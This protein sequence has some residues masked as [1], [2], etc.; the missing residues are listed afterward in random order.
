VKRGWLATGVLLVCIS[1]LLPRGLAPVQAQSARALELTLKQ[2]LTGHHGP[3]EAL[4]ISPDGLRVAL[5]VGSYVH[6]LRLESGKLERTLVGHREFVTSVAWSRDGRTLASASD[7]D[8]V[9]LWNASSGTSLHVLTGVKGDINAVAFSPDGKRLAAGGDDKLVRIWDV[10]SGTPGRVLRGTSTRLRAL[11]W[12][13]DARALAVAS[14]DAIVRVYDPTSGK[15][16]RELP[17]A[18]DGSRA[19]AFSAD[20]K[21]AAAGTDALIRLWGA[22]SNAPRVLRGHERTV[23]GLAFAKDGRQLASVGF[24][25]GVRLWN[26]RDGSSRQFVGHKDSV[27]ALAFVPVNR[28]AE[29]QLI[30]ASS[31]G[32]ART[33]DLKSAE[34]IATLTAFPSATVAL[35]WHPD[36]SRIASAA[37]E[38][39]ITVFTRSNGAA[40]RWAGHTGWV[41]DLEWSADGQRLASV[42]DEGQLIIWSQDGSKLHVVR[43]TDDWLSSVAWSPDGAH[44]AI[45][46]ARG[47]IGIWN[48]QSGLLER[49]L[50]GHTAAILS[51][52]WSPN[53]QFI[54]SGSSDSSVKLWR[55]RDGAEIYVLNEFAEWTRA[56]AWSADSTRFAVASDDGL[57]S[58][59]AASSG[60]RLEVFRHGPGFVGGLAWSAD[61][62]LLATAGDDGSVRL[63][64]AANAAPLAI[65]KRHSDWTEGLAF[66]ADG[67][68]LAVGAGTLAS[69]GTISLYAAR[70]GDAVFGPAPD[71]GSASVDPVD[72]TSKPNPL[73]IP[74][75]FVSL[76]RLGLAAKV[77]ASYRAGQFADRIRL[78]RQEEDFTV[79]LR[80]IP[81]ANFDPSRTSLL[82]LALERVRFECLFQTR[83]ERCG[84]PAQIQ[85]IQTPFG[86]E[87]YQIELTAYDRERAGDRLTATPF[88]PVIALNNL[89]SD[90]TQPVLLLIWLEAR[91]PGVVVL[92][93][94]TKL[95]AFLEEFALEPR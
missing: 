50:T 29:T 69:G 7:D 26:L 86:L 48:A 41:R 13:S 28:G 18:S 3:I 39:N 67:T 95:E 63:W 40:Q 53:G 43:G 31:D 4:A 90:Q 88:T 76:A 78:E 70:D 82:E 21:L 47:V 24:D 30:T 57:V 42:G 83:A 38:T 46:G 64:N 68:A 74:K 27:N 6:L 81:L 54:V 77:A 1:S 14:D 17:A 9:R 62:Q 51:I 87:G 5:A 93:A 19:I 11:A 66:S 20:G 73:E 72:A 49:E 22:K 34:Q 65:L 10:S 71:I 12:R 23:L 92:D 44:L 61:G 56:V 33:W 25:R 79:M 52:A 2:T 75:D 45:A 58:I 85:A 37:N 8:T 55:A 15:V 35:A 91:T 84:D 32:S 89:G 36:S 94:Q 80:S 60:T 59:W 16:L